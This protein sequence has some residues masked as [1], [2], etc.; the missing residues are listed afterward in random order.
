MGEEE[1]RFLSKRPTPPTLTNSE[2][3]LFKEDFQEYRW[4][5][6]TRCNNSLISSDNLEIGHV[7]I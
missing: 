1:G 2:Q 4:R 6:G 7:V 3:D 5:E